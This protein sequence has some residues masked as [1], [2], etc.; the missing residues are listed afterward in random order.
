LPAGY[1]DL[2]IRESL[3]APRILYHPLLRSERHVF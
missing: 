2:N 1:A 3:I